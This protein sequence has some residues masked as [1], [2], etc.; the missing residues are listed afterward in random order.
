MLA[1][2]PEDEASLHAAAQAYAAAGWPV[3]PLKP[4]AKTPLTTHGLH[5]ASTDADEIADWWN[6]WP[7]AN[8]GLRTGIAFDVLDID[9]DAGLAS[10]ASIAPGYK[11]AGPV[12]GTGRGHH[13]LFAVTLAKNG[14]NLLPKLD[15]RGNGGYIV[16][17][18][19]IHPDGHTYQ[20][21]RS[22]ALPFPEAPDWLNTLLFPKKPAA[23]TPRPTS[24]TLASAR[25]SLD[26]IG[27]LSALGCEFHQKG[28]RVVTRCPLGTHSDS[29]PSF[30]IY[31]GPPPNFNCFGCGAWG[32]ALNIRYFREHGILR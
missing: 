14:A 32:D 6:R 8:I 7:A 29:T 13:L 30:T 23:L 12:S 3:L 25:D 18:P 5:D 17:P 11:H 20:W 24:A 26:L 22:P 1:P 19:S 9:G 2:S 16:A 15:F 28:G 4:R 10:V 27:E 21:L 31:P